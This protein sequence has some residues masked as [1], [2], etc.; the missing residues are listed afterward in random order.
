MLPILLCS[1]VALAIVI[2]RFWALQAQKINP[3][4]LLGRINS[5]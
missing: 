4:F 5:S 1:V 3:D 2:E